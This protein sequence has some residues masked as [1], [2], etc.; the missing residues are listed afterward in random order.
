[1]RVS[2]TLMKSFKSSF[3]SQ[4]FGGQQ[5]PHQMA[6]PAS[7][8][9]PTGGAM[10]MMKAPAIIPTRQSQPRKLS[11]GLGGGKDGRTG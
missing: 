3:S 7:M 9:N 1:M 4:I 8:I 6:N 10:G 5:Q 11:G 2:Q